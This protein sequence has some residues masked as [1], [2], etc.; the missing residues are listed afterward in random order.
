VCGFI[1]PRAP[2]NYPLTGAGS[3][4]TLHDHINPTLTK[5]WTQII[6]SHSSKF[7]HHRK[8]NSLALCGRENMISTVRGWLNGSKTGLLLKSKSRPS[9]GIS[10]EFLRM[11]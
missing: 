11:P 2:L 9:G 1:H 3:L 6:R 5:F 10:E 8:H 7:I 4:P